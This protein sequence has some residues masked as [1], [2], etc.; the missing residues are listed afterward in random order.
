MRL[1]NNPDGSA[2]PLTLAAV[3]ILAILGIGLLSLA[4][5]SYSMQAS[6]HNR[7]AARL[8]AE[9][10][11]EKVYQGIKTDSAFVK[12]GEDFVVK[13]EDDASS[14]SATCR[15][16]GQADGSYLIR[17][18]GTSGSA[19]SNVTMAATPGLPEV[20]THGVYA[21]LG[22]TGKNDDYTKNQV[23]GSDI[24]SGG[25]ISG[26]GAPGHDVVPNRPLVFPTVDPANYNWWP[27]PT[28]TGDDNKKT[29]TIGDTRTAWLADD[30]VAKNNL[31]IQGPGTLA[32]GGSMLDKNSMTI[33]GSVVL[34]IL[35][36]LTSKN[37]LEA[38]EIKG[39][40]LHLIVTGDMTLG[41]NSKVDGS[42]TVGGNLHVDLNTQVRYVPPLL[43][44]MPEVVGGT[45]VWERVWIR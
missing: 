22:I 31:V 37:N 36:D 13:F 6:Q 28:I 25:S 3:V 26:W 44:D 4:S 45:R 8:I 5:S 15:V 1:L 34:I 14:K 2:L 42:I 18:T 11:A 33:H 40:L 16:T 38:V 41:N 23:L 10:G 27:A 35:G 43:A 30:V 20:Y 17:S 19:S 12:Y 39:G 32:V 21:G 29:I 9:G 24:V 7:L